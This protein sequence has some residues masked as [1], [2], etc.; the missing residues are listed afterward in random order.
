M[1]NI[2]MGDD[3]LEKFRL[4]LS[5]CTNCDLVSSNKNFSLVLQLETTVTLVL[6]LNETKISIKHNNPNWRVAD[7]LALNKHD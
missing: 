2:N 1:E 7:Q 5:R 6:Q 4:K 3:E